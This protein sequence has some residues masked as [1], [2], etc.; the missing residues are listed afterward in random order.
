MS[1]RISSICC[2]RNRESIRQRDPPNQRRAHHSSH[3]RRRRHEQVHP[4]VAQHIPPRLDPPALLMRALLRHDTPGLLARPG[5]RRL[6]ARLD[7][8]R[9]RRILRAAHLRAL[10]Q[11]QRPRAVHGHLAPAL[12]LDDPARPHVHD[13]RLQQRAQQRVEQGAADADGRDGGDERALRRERPRGA[14]GR[15]RDGRQR[16]DGR[17]ERAREQSPRRHAAVGAG[18]DG[19][20]GRGDEARARLGEDAQL[21]GER[22]GGDGGVVGDDADDGQVSGRGPAFCLGG[23]GPRELIGVQEDE[24]GGD[25]RVGEDLD[26]GARAFA[27]GGAGGRLGEA[28]FDVVLDLERKSV[29]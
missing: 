21:G 24:D 1:D 8:R 10:L 3:A 15:E 28:G 4:I 22:V 13:A 29:V 17:A 26:V 2:L 23:G 6:R 9:G 19:A 20:P 11:V 5:L 18:R 12:A 7:A 16:D 14:E 25:E 27:A